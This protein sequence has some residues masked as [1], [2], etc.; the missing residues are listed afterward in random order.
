MTGK[1]CQPECAQAGSCPTRTWTTFRMARCPIVTPAAC[2]DQWTRPHGRTDGRASRINVSYHGSFRI[3]SQG[4]SSR[5]FGTHARWGPYTLYHMRWS[6]ILV[7]K[8]GKFNPREVCV[9]VRARVCRHDTLRLGSLSRFAGN[10]VTMFFFPSRS[11][12]PP[13]DSGPSLL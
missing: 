11:R 9:C 10:T 4:V 8:T 7:I 13:C 3:G 6:F 12:C 5:F 2:R 1:L